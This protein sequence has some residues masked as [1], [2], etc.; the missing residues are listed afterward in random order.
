MKLKYNF[1]I[2][3]IAG[4]TVAIPIDTD[5]GE[6]C[7]IKT[8]EAGAHILELLKNEISL[9]QIIDDINQNFE[10]EDQSKLNAWVV[11]F[12]EKLK[13]ADVLENE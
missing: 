2:S 3:E 5:G 1:I 10:V 13:N 7:A 9:D 12:I 6:Q 4:Q 8:N 11:S